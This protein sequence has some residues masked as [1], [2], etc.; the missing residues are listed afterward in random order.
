MILIVRES[1]AFKRDLKRLGRGNSNLSKL[2][3]IVTKLAKQEKLEEKYSDHLLT[4]NWKGY[5]DCHITPDWVLIYRIE[6][7]ELLLART[8]SHSEL[9]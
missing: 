4:G 7:D 3:T 8:G 5:R 9:F 1:N 6:G 2:G